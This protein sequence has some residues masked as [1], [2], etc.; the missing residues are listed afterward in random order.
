M[1]GHTRN[2]FFSYS[3]E[4]VPKY[5]LKGQVLTKTADAF[6]Y[7]AWR[8]MDYVLNEEG[9]VLDEGTY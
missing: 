5:G 1:P 6:Y 2:E 3:A 9:G 8:D 7:S 4:Q